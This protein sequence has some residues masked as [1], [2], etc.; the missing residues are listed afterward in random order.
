MHFSSLKRIIPTIYIAVVF[1][2]TLTAKLFVCY[3]I[4]VIYESYVSYNMIVIHVRVCI[5]DQFIHWF[6]VC[7][8]MLWKQCMLSC[9]FIHFILENHPLYLSMAASIID[10]WQSCRNLQFCNRHMWTN[11]VACDIDFLV[12]EDKE[13]VP[14]HKYIL[15]SRS[16]VF[17]TM[18]CGP[19]AETQREITLPDIEPPVF[20]ALLEWVLSV[21][22]QIMILVSWPL[23]FFNLCGVKVCE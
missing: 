19:L 13:R 21:T 3:I 10:D 12:G 9:F 1:I 20:K 4:H 16:C 11:Q 15:I 22:V 2:L 23:K 7:L 8:W 5:D 18:F 6:N 14:A 17:F